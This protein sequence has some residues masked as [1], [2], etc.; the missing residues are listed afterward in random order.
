M[1]RT[2]LA[3]ACGWAC[4]GCIAHAGPTVAWRPAGKVAIGWQ[5]GAGATALQVIAGESYVDGRAFGYGA[6]GGHAVGDGWMVGGLLGVGSAGGR[7]AGVIGAEA[8][9]FVS[10]SD[11][12][13]RW[14]AILTVGA[15]YLGGDVELF[16]R[17]ALA[18]LVSPR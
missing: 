9:G 2:A 11:E 17:P 5:A 13:G 8:A 3:I 10:P 6:L 16:A 15:R 1:G 18:Y 4:A 14:V 12:A 7:G